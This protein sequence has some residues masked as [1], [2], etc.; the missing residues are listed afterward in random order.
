MGGS[1]T[2]KRHRDEDYA[3]DRAKRAR[4][5]RRGSRHDGTNNLCRFESSDSDDSSVVEIISEDG[6]GDNPDEDVG[7][8]SEVSIGAYEEESEEDD[9][10][11]DSE[12]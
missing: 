3:D 8:R 4:F 5:S 7:S 6:D 12:W 11:S 1:S 9:S 10:D 2:A